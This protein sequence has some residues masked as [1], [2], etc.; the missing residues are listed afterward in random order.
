MSR[1]LLVAVFLVAS[2]DSFSAVPSA[3]FLG[4]SVRISGVTPGGAVAYVSISIEPSDWLNRIVARDGFIADDD[5][6]GVVTIE[7]G[8]RPAL[9]SVWGIVDV[10]S[11]ASSVAAP[12]GFTSALMDPRDRMNKARGIVGS[13]DAVEIERNELEILLVRPGVGAWRLTAN[14]GGA[15]D[16]DRSA[17]RMVRAALNA[18]TA[19]GP[20]GSPPSRV[21]PGDVA[22]ALDPEELSHYQI[23]VGR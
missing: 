11:G 6:D 16:A 12:E 4:Q 10:S 23:I 5:R 9:R 3:Q 1:F 14:D 17:N 21:E 7:L 8:A 15:A 2:V 20:S 18:M 19:L 22:I 13:L